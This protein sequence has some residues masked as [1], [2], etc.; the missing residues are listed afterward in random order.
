MLLLSNTMWRFIPSPNVFKT[1][2]VETLGLGSNH[3]L[4]VYSLKYTCVCVTPYIYVSK[5]S[6]RGV[7]QELCQSVNSGKITV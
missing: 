3:F 7:F 2:Q 6:P 5:H 1:S 4:L